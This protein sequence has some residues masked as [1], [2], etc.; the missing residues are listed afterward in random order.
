MPEQPRILYNLALLENSQSNFKE[1]E[2]Y[3]LKALKAEPD[4]FDFLYAI[5]TFYLQKNQKI[6]AQKYAKHIMAK[7]PNNPTGKQLLQE[8]LK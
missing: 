5:C 8:T 6:E 2:N 7:F 3:F 1:A 4:N